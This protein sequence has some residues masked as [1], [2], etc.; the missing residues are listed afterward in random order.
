MIDRKTA[1]EQ[2]KRLHWL[3]YPHTTNRDAVRELVDELQQDTESPD[4]AERTVSSILDSF[5]K[6]PLPRDVR[7]IAYELRPERPENTCR[8]CGGS[9]YVVRDVGGYSGA[10][11]CACRTKP[12]EATG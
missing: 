3:F 6:C 8:V 12:Q 7:R 9:G 11:P 5:E 2:V 4:H 10:A 1:A